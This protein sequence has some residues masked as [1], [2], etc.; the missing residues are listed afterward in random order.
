[1]APGTQAFGRQT[2]EAANLD[3]RL[4]ALLLLHEPRMP[5]NRRLCL[6]LH[7][8]QAQRSEAVQLA[9]RGDIGGQAGDLDLRLRAA[10]TVGAE[11]HDS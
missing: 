10:D 7:L 3:A 11:Y 9:L 1:M 5:G 4:A 8:G 2:G 6:L